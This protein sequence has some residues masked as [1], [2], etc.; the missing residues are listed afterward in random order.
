M[1]GTQQGQAELVAVGEGDL[2][3]AGLFPQGGQVVPLALALDFG[4]CSIGQ[5]AV[6]RRLGRG[7]GDAE[8]LAVILCQPSLPLRVAEPGDENC[9]QAEFFPEVRMFLE[10]FTAVGLAGDA[11]GFLSAGPVTSQVDDGVALLNVIVQH[12]QRG[13]AVKEKFLLRLDAHAGSVEERGERV[14][15]RAELVGHGGDEESGGVCGHGVSRSLSP[16][17]GR[18]QVLLLG[19]QARE[20]R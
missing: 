9:I 11:T 2:R 5:D 10:Q 15:I 17:V 19:G 4:R 8:L 1:Q 6:T 14:A 16:L 7:R 12:E 18:G 20:I 3:V 13:V